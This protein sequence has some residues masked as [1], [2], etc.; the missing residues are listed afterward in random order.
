LLIFFSQVLPLSISHLS[1]LVCGM[2]GVWIYLSL[3][4]RKEYLNS[5]RLALEKKTLHPEMLR[6]PIADSA[7]LEPILRV[8]DSPDERQVLYAVDPLGR[9]EPAFWSAHALRC[10]NTILPGYALWP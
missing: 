10:F 2:I 3:A 7:T 9:R 6:L 4:I 5:F 1:L 8:L